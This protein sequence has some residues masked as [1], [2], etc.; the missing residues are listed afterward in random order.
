VPLIYKDIIKPKPAFLYKT[1]EPTLVIQAKAQKKIFNKT[2]RPIYIRLIHSN[3]DLGLVSY[4]INKY[5]PFRTK[6]SIAKNIR[7]TSF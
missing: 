7:I 2:I 4:K 3:N 1:I 6:C 5:I